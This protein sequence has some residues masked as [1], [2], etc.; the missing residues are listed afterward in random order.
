MQIDE[1]DEIDINPITMPNALVIDDFSSPKKLN[2]IL[3]VKAKK[4]LKGDVLFVIDCSESM[5]SV[6]NNKIK[7]LRILNE[8]INTL[9][10][11][12]KNAIDDIDIGIIGWDRDAYTLSLTRD[13]NKVSDF[14]HNN[15]PN[16]DVPETNFA[17]ALDSSLKELN[18]SNR[19][20]FENMSR[21]IIIITDGIRDGKEDTF[22]DKEGF[23]NKAKEKGYKIFSIGFGMPES[24][25]N[26]FQNMSSLTQG[27]YFNYEDNVLRIIINKINESLENQIVARNAELTYVL[28]PYLDRPLLDIIPGITIS[29]VDDRWMIKWDIGDIN[30]GEKREISFETN[31]NPIVP[32]T[33][34][35]CETKTELKYVN[36]MNTPRT[37]II[38]SEFELR[39]PTIFRLI[40]N[41]LK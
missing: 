15:L 38:G 31:F 24:S 27:E 1:I 12:G 2:I 3:E 11:I 29:L 39:P 35:A 8:F 18:K 33:S 6:D 30:A 36:D 17:L 23:A 9:G 21:L 40:R 37:K 16:D 5:Q 41:K 26:S 4:K 13:R 20:Q 22:W 14:A 25:R 28:Q 34:K 32:I 19:N 10:I 7:R